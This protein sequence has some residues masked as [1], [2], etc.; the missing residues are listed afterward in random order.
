MSNKKNIKDKI[1]EITDECTGIKVFFVD[2]NNEVFDSDID[3][4]T[5]DDYRKSYVENLKTNYIENESFTTPMLSASDNRGNALYQ[6]DFKKEE[7]P[8]EFGFLNK[9]NS[10]KP[11]DKLDQYKVRI[12]G[13]NKLRGYIIRLRSATG[14][15]MSFYQYIHHSAMVT[16]K[17]GAFLTVHKTRVVK[18]D[19]DVLRL[20]E[21][22]IVA[23]IDD[24]YLIENVSAL[25]KELAFDKVIHKRA[26]Q[27]FKNLDESNLVE[28]LDKFKK[29]IENETAF[30]RK[31]VKIYRNSPVIEQNLSNEDVIKFAMSKDFYKSKLKLSEDEKQFDLNSIDRCNNFL[32]LLDDDFLKSELTQQNYIAK[33]KDR[34]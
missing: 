17:R 15:V 30:A 8:I 18:L 9:V 27:Y 11:N 20:N 16:P 25:E 10:L 7:R 14:K 22:F 5:L 23:L 12:N 1:K 2:E 33:S 32:T 21:K 26:T 6:F 13:L 4:S 28:D 19:H 24:L 34:A 29:R 3:S 31:F